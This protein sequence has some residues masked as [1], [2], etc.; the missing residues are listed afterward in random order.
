[1]LTCILSHKLKRP[2]R[3]CPRWV[4][5]G[6]KNTPSMHHAW[7]L[8]VTTSMVGLKTVTYAKISHKMVNPRDIA[9]EHRRP[10]EHC[11]SCLASTRPAQHVWWCDTC[12]HVQDKWEGVWTE[13]R[14]VVPGCCWQLVCGQA[15]KPLHLFVSVSVCV[16]VCVCV[17]FYVYLCLCVSQCVWMC[18]CICVCVCM[19]VCVWTYLCVCMSVCVCVCVCVCV[20]VCVRA[21]MQ[22]LVCVCF[23]V[24]VFTLSVSCK[25]RMQLSAYSG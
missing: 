22:I 7:R 23:D 12:V 10:C 24:P 8:N 1:M 25:F 15:F 19:C 16:C 9:G 2:W 13:H 21:H 4:N 6:N 3:S 11:S 17:C 18:V 20:R 5:A 14:L